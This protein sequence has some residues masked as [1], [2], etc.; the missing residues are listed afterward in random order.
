MIFFVVQDNSYLSNAEYIETQARAIAHR[1]QLICYPELAF[2]KKLPLGTYV[3]C[4]LDRLTDAERE[5]ALRAWDALSAAGSEVRLL[6]HPTKTMLRYDLLRWLNDSGFNQFRA[7][8]VSETTSPRRYPVFLRMENDHT[9]DIGGLLHNQ[10]QLYAAL[11]RAVLLGYHLRDLLIVEYCNTACADGFFRKYSAF[12]V[13]DQ[14]LP[15]FS[16]VNRHW[17]VKAAGQH[18]DESTVMEER[19]F[20]CENPHGATLREIFRQARVEYGRV[21]YSVLDGQLQ[22]WEINLCPTIGRG[23]L[24]Q[25]ASPLME[26]YRP[27]REV[28]R[29]HFYRRFQA[30]LEGI[31]SGPDPRCE[32]PFSLPA[33]LRE[34]YKRERAHLR[35]A[36]V[37]RNFVERVS[38]CSWMERA[39]RL[40]AP[41]LRK[42][43][44]VLN[45]ARGTT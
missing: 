45:R 14:V 17:M 1:L 38:Y 33:E 27:L 29:Q 42:E 43:T 7:Y 6:N 39:K 24:V 2:R 11:A 21:D 26:K 5:I 44:A 22:I 37:Y 20:I 23:P 16:N 31:D 3:F 9:G 18:M 34:R 8:R 10:T 35:R 19:R 36:T 12:V 32:I 30:A 25:S 4:A 41:L 15:R 40:A 13:G 28:G